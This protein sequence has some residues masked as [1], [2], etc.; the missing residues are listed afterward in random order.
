LSVCDELNE[1]ITLTAVTEKRSS[2]LNDY[3]ALTE[4]NQAT[5]NDN[6]VETAN[7]LID[8]DDT[9]HVTSMS[10]SQSDDD[11]DKLNCI[12]IQC[13]QHTETDLKYADTVTLT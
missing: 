12:G 6:H 9:S 11:H 10:P 2:A 8:I 3:D 7:A 5:V 1:A 4:A 13:G